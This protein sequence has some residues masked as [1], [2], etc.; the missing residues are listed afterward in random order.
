M[1][2]AHGVQDIDVGTQLPSLRTLHT[3]AEKGKGEN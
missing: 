1:V 3:V 2:F